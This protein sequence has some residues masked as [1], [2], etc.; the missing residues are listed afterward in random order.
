M[1]FALISCSAK[2]FHSFQ[3]NILE[4]PCN[5]TVISKV[6]MRF[7]NSWN[8]SHP[9]YNAFGLLDSRTMAS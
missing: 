2:F 1:W 6:N 9:S 8:V 3:L 4:R 7:M 5:S